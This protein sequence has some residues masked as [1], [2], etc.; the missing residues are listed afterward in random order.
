VAYSVKL[1]PA[2]ARQFRDLPRQ[3]QERLQPRIDA[4][5][6][7]PRPSGVKKM[8]GATDLFRIRVGDYRVVYQVDDAAQSIIIAKVADRKDVYRRG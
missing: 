7:D 3:V 8:E 4:L 5:A 6:D 2:A 1:S